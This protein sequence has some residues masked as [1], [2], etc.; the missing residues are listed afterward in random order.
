MGKK[1]KELQQ[2]QFFIFNFFNRE[3]WASSKSPEHV[4][5]EKTKGNTPTFH[6]VSERPEGTQGP[7]TLKQTQLNENHV[8]TVKMF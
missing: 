4:L 1:E 6:D 5:V 3:K 2:S 8:N 7:M